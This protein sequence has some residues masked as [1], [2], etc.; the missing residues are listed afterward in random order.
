MLV[1]S[2]SVFLGA[3]LLFLIQPVIAKMILPWF[4]GSAAVW[5]TCLAFFQTLLLFGYLYSHHT[6]RRLSPRIQIPLH[7][8]LLAISLLLLPFAPDPG[9]KP[10]GDEDPSLRILVLLSASIGLPYFLLATTGPLIQVWYARTF[11]AALPYRLFALSNLASLAALLSYPVLIEPWTS[12]RGQA[13]AWS[14]AYVVYAAFTITAALRSSKTRS[15]A[16]FYETGPPSVRQRAEW[17][18]LAAGASVL[19]LSVTNHLTQNLASIPFLWVLPLSLYLLSFVLCFDRDG[20]YRRG[21]F[22]WIVSAA[23]VAMSYGMLIFE[24]AY[25]LEITIPIFLAGLFLC[26]LFC[27]GELALRRPPPA[28]LT[29]FYLMIALGGAAGGL[30]T[31]LVAPRAFSNFLELP[32]GVVFCSL[33]A[34]YFLYQKGSRKNLVLLYVLAGA[35]F[36]AVMYER[37]LAADVRLARRGFY[38]GLRIMDRSGTRLLLNGAVSHGA[39]LLKP[40]L[41]REPTTYYGRRSGVGVAF[42]DLPDAPRRIGVIG[43]GAGTLA[44]YAREQDVLR[45]YEINPQVVDLARREFTFLNDS[46]A[47]IEVVLGD[48]RLSLERERPQTY[49]LL[50][51]DAFSG[52]SIP[53]HLLSREA[54]AV[55]FRHLKP[56]GLLAMHISNASLDLW[57]VVYAS[58]TA[59]GKL[60]MLVFSPT[61]DRVAVSEAAWAVIASDRR[62]FARPELSNTA[63]LPETRRIRVWTDDYSNVGQLLK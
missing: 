58:A 11:Q 26:C 51:V 23:L 28:Q 27:H 41:R 6:T 12:T 13:L 62:A 2:T 52:D 59:Q 55:F 7:C 24:P 1:Y 19:L 43:L 14:A 17:L 53:A 35:V 29:S 60:P 37:L 20:W 63:F 57:P 5:T 42:A 39:Q 45:F 61:D 38:G 34:L 4:G 22:L 21:A 56:D 8:S 44:V 9:W 47:R 15:K 33:L 3:F 49:D 40:E 10:A 54:M 50:V 46:P 18:L 30:F 25:T 16:P 31:G 32:I 36:T 48:G